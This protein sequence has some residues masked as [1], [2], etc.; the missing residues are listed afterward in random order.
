MSLG[1][2]PVTEECACADC[3]GSWCRVSLRA[4]VWLSVRTLLSPWCVAWDCLASRN[5][6]RA[7]RDGGRARWLFARSQT[8]VVPAGQR[9]QICYDSGRTRS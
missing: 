7:W 3:S 6:D 1:G 4:H 8:P 5:L 9:S 2:F